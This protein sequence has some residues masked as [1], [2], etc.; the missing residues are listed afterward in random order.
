MLTVIA[1]VGIL[2]VIAIPSWLM[3]AKG[4]RLKSA[5]ESARVMIRQASAEASRQKVLYQAMFRER[6]NRVEVGALEA[7]EATL[8]NLPASLDAIEWKLLPEG[9]AIDTTSNYLF[10]LDTTHNFYWIR[11]KE[12]GSIA[13]GV[14]L[15][16]NDRITLT[17]TE[18][19][20]NTN[21]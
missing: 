21:R 3:C 5:G 6:N 14:N 12:D 20:N 19:L 4:R 15:A 11:F 9:I 10:P 7:D 2:A 16:A 13:D 1:I 18:D 17:T 8:N